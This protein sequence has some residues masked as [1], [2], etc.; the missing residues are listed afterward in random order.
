MD[1]AAASSAEAAGPLQMSDSENDGAVQEQVDCETGEK[2]R[3]TTGPTRPKVLSSKPIQYS[4][5]ALDA[6]VEGIALI[7]CTLTTE[8]NLESCYIV[9]GLPHLD[10]ALIASLQGWKFSPALCHGKPINV[11]LVLPIRVHFP[12]P[13][14]T[15]APGSK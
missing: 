6:R 4:R 9:R 12:G 13:P 7:K 5:A 2:G 11:Q 3:S 8:G 1:P 15:A 10:N 14:A